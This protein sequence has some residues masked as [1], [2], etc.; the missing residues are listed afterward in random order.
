VVGWDE[1]L[2]HENARVDFSGDKWP[3]AEDVDTL[4]S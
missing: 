1:I 3:T 2:H 4:S